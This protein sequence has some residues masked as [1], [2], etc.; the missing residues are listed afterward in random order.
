MTSE[1]Q[2]SKHTCQPSTFDALRRDFRQFS[3]RYP[4]DLL[5]QMHTR[6]FK[7]FTFSIIIQIY[8][9]KPLVI[10][11]VVIIV[12]IIAIIVIRVIIIVVI[13][14]VIIIVIIVIVAQIVFC[15]IRALIGALGAR[16]KRLSAVI[17]ALS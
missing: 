15:C 4:S 13:V 14:I 6:L 17:S 2:F 10:V 16:T 9:T 11:I 1:A 8:S 5:N 3:T 12:I 7:P